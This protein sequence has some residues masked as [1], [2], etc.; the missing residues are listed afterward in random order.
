LIESSPA[1]TAYFGHADPFG[2]FTG[3]ERAVA[4]R[5]PIAADVPPLTLADERRRKFSQEATESST[6]ASEAEE[7]PDPPEHEPQTQPETQEAPDQVDTPKPPTT[8]RQP[9]D[10]PDQEEGTKLDEAPSPADDPN[11]EIQ[12]LRRELARLRAENGRLRRAENKRTAKEAEGLQMFVVGTKWRWYAPSGTQN[13]YFGDGVC[14]SSSRKNDEMPWFATSGNEAG[15][16][17][18]GDGRLEFTFDDKREHFLFVD[19]K[20]DYRCGR[21]LGRF[22]PKDRPARSVATEKKEAHPA[23]TTIDQLRDEID[24]LEGENTDIKSDRQRDKTQPKDLREHLLGTKWEWNNGD[25]F[26]LFTEKGSWN[27]DFPDLV[28]RWTVDSPRTVEAIRSDGVAMVF[29]FNRGRTHFLCVTP[30]GPR[31][32][33][34]AE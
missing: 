17:R 9:Q 32:G 22:D 23:P 19:D 7:E 34:L 12:S 26:Y 21:F 8:E 11:S 31:C 16:P 30:R 10:S 25:S 24:R 29:T 15:V 13:F 18:E 14:W 4:E 1:P 2:I 28:S 33:K 27:S 5:P 6:S 20:K 3:Q